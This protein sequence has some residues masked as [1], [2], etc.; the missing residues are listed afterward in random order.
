MN[1]TESKSDSTD[2]TFNT[3]AFIEDFSDNKAMQDELD[4][5][6]NTF[7]F[8]FVEQA[9]P[10]DDAYFYN[11]ATTS[12]PAGTDSVPVTW[13]AFPGRLSQYFSAS[14]PV[15]PNNPYNLNPD[16]LRELADTGSYTKAD[17]TTQAIQDIPEVFCPEADWNGTLNPFLP[18]GPR[19]WQD[20]YCEWAVQKNADDKITRV[21]FVCENPEYWHALWSV[22]PQKAAQLYQD[23][24]NYG[25]PQTQHIT[26]T[27]DDLTLK[28][29]NGDPVINPDTNQPAYNPLN[30]WNNSPISNRS[31]GNMTGGVMHL[32]ST[33]NTLQ[34]EIGLAGFSTPQFE[35]GNS[36]QQTLLC[37]GQFG[38]AYRHS[39]PH[40]GQTVNQVVGGQFIQGEY[41]SINLANPFG[42]YIQKPA[43]LDSWSFGPNIQPGTNVPADAKASDIWQVVRGNE[44]VT[45]PVTGSAF[46][47]NMIL[48]AVCQIPLSWLEM[49]SSLT[50]DDILI[51]GTPI[52][53]GAQI[54]E[55]IDIGLFAR[56][57]PETEKPPTVPCAG[58]TPAG[59]P[60]QS[61]PQV[62]WDAM[63]AK[64]E[65]NP[66]GSVLS[67]ASN[68]VIIPSVVTPGE[69]AQIA[70][71]VEKLSA[72]AMPEVNVLT[73][74]SGGTIDTSILV[75]VSS[76]TDVTYAVPGN[77][78]PGTY[79]SL[80]LEVNAE[81]SAE[82]GFRAVAVQYGG[83]EAQIMSSVFLVS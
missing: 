70:L 76:A 31:T 50:L 22:S 32:T 71:T 66:A 38:Q 6:W 30:K 74:S 58:L 82:A 44:T 65:S 7:L 73:A 59:A 29:D 51:N 17:N 4:G 63:Y 78:G 2:F 27:V 55:Q 47:G 83:N 45:D 69:T 20:E 25:A 16:Q 12:I 36:D 13:N 67:L 33:P 52:T 54:T 57:L 5:I 64:E 49:D 81:S 60:L 72:D 18:Y 61:L 41:F 10:S 46:D 48:H 34:T 37:C 8:A 35:S 14:P 77:S 3:P 15:Q 23:T 79:T 19:G 9:T 28:D 24:L 39:D 62:I 80:S 26:V 75:T 42:L 43:G 11:P 40:I 53:R 56:P 1:N 21:D 68:S